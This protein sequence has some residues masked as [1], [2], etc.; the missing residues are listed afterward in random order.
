MKILRISEC[1]QQIVLL[2]NYF[3]AIAGVTVD[4]APS[5]PD[6]VGMVSGSTF[7]HDAERKER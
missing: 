3:V 4:K 1:S 2:F 6:V 7:K 5:V